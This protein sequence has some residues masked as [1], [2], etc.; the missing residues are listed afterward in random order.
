VDVAP[1]ADGSGA[2]ETTAAASVLLEPLVEGPD[3]PLPVLGRAGVT[4]YLGTGD[5][6]VP[7]VSVATAD[8]LR[9]PASLQLAEPLPGGVG[10]AR[11]GLG[12]VL[13]DT[14]CVRVRRWWRPPAPV[15]RNPRRASVR[16]AAAAPLLPPLEP[17]VA[18]AVAPLLEAV[19]GGD[20]RPG[21]ARAVAGLVGL[22][23]GLTPAGD[24]VLVGA[25]VALRALE[26]GGHA[27]PG[28]LA[29]DLARAAWSHGTTTLSAA[30]LQD[31]GRG[32][33]VPELAAVLAA[34][35][36]R[37]ELTTSVSRLLAVGHSSGAAMAHGAVLVLTATDVKRARA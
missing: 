37:G 26:R 3:R 33:C 30:L 23:G 21:P 12:R 17:A 25:L 31:A 29:S 15:V 34:A 35:D 20:A 5:A 7:L 28:R 11:A 4:V 18:A 10:T 14:V 27:A 8:A 24:D 16:A 19:R 36:G 2:R 1:T 9:L 13:L 22:G 6:D 32:W